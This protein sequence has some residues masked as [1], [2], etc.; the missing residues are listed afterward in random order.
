MI[1]VLRNAQ[2]VIMELEQPIDKVLEFEYDMHKWQEDLLEELA[3]KAH[4]R[5]II[6]YND[7]KGGQ[8]KSTF[9]KYLAEAYASRTLYL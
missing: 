1:T 9:G 4:P 8:G 2:K 3:V 5:K 6:W 7:I